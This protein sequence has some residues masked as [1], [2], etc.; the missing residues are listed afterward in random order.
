MSGTAPESPA[1]RAF[2]LAVIGDF[3]S[4]LCDLI[5]GADDGGPGTRKSPTK[6]SFSVAS[7]AIFVE[8]ALRQLLRHRRQLDLISLLPEKREPLT[9]SLP[10]T[11]ISLGKF[12]K[13][14]HTS[15][16]DTTFR[17]RS[18]VQQLD[19][20]SQCDA[21]EFDKLSTNDVPIAIGIRICTSEFFLSI[22][23]MPVYHRH[24][25]F[26]ANSHIRSEAELILN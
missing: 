14:N 12:P 3:G 11:N 8:M 1:E 26:V 21:S 6:Q 4:D 9:V 5:D 19:S 25:C 24:I 15:S 10:R 13:F 17:I 18:S 16:K 23:N 22:Q 2:K 7:G 20:Q